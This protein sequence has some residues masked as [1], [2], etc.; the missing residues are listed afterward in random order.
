VAFSPI[1]LLLQ[2]QTGM[3]CQAHSCHTCRALEE[4]DS[5]NADRFG[6]LLDA[7]REQS[8]GSGESDLRRLKRQFST[9]K[10]TFLHY[11]VKEAF[12]DGADDLLRAAHC[13]CSH[14][15]PA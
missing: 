3:S 15:I 12:I 1:L 13:P 11:D 4:L 8:A 5:A 14:I 7:A 9:L 10:N 6:R 2:L